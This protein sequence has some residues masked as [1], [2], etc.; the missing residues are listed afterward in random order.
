MALKERPGTLLAKSIARA[1][2]TARRAWGGGRLTREERIE[3]MRRRRLR[4]EAEAEAA[5]QDE[6]G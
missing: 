4:R 3:R 1:G 5:E 2:E 6:E